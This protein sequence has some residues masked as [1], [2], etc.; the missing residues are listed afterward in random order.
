MLSQFRQWFNTIKIRQRLLLAFGLLVII[1]FIPFMAFTIIEAPATHALD[2]LEAIRYENDLVKS[3]EGEIQTI[4]YLTNRGGI[5][6]LIGRQE[7]AIEY[8]TD[9]VADTENTLLLIEQIQATD[10]ESLTED[11]E[12]MALLEDV[13]SNLN[14]YREAGNEILTDIVP[15]RLNGTTGDGLVRD[16]LI[17]LE[18]I[19]AQLTINDVLLVANQYVGSFNRD[20]VVQLPL[21][22]VGLEQRINQSELSD[23]T[24]AELQDLLTDARSFLGELLIVDFRVSRLFNQMGI[25]VNNSIDLLTV[26]ITTQNALQA[27]LQTTYDN[28]NATRQAITPVIM[29]SILTVSITL[30]FFLSRTLTK[31]IHELTDATQVIASGNYGKRVDVTRSDEIGQLATAFNQMADVIEERDGTLKAQSEALNVALSKAEESSRLKSEFLAT[32]SHELRTPL[33]AIIGYS[34]LLEMGGMG[35]LDEK[36][37][38]AVTTIQKSGD[39]LLAMINDILDLAKIESGQIT[40]FEYPMEIKTQID[41]WQERMALSAE[42]KGLAF[43]TVIDPDLPEELVVDWERLSQIVLNLL[44]NAVKFTKQGSITL[45]VAQKSKAEWMICVTDTGIGMSQT[46]IDYIFEEFRQVDGSHQRS[47]EGT[48]LGLAIVRKLSRKM[49]GDVRVSSEPNRGSTF[50][51][52]LPLKVP[53]S[54]GD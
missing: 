30:P 27:S 54:A 2:S 26:Y 18:A 8:Y 50:T 28:A 16:L 47:Y 35:E 43:K 22:L 1:N 51:V 24:K 9:A 13:H 12:L 52:V 25:D 37:H 17:P 41:V 44:S 34:G 4:R 46:A 14:S 7:R 31:P 33:N 5:E 39:H 3:V 29:L 40:L 45:E 36:V 53:T 42:Y 15:L 38:K 11:V 20:A 32:M 6:F 48:G 23:S 19:N 49:Q 21:A 10:M